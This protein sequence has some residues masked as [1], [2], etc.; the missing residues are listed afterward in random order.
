MRTILFAASTAMAFLSTGIADVSAKPPTALLTVGQCDQ[1]WE[2]SGDLRIV[3]KQTAAQK[4]ALAACIGQRSG[5]EVTWGAGLPAPDQIWLDITSNADDGYTD[6]RFNSDD[7]KWG[8][9][10]RS[11]T[12][13]L[14]VSSAGFCE[15]VA[16]NLRQVASALEGKAF[17]TTPASNPAFAAVD[18]TPDGDVVARCGPLLDRFEPVVSTGPDDLRLG[19]TVEEALRTGFLGVPLQKQQSRDEIHALIDQAQSGR[20]TEIA[21]TKPYLGYKSARLSSFFECGKLMSMDIALK[22]FVAGDWARLAK[23]VHSRYAGTQPGKTELA[24]MKAKKK[25]CVA[26]MSKDESVNLI[27]RR[28]GAKNEAWLR[29]GDPRLAEHAAKGCKA[30]LGQRPIGQ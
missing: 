6:V 15:A 20:L 19:M 23:T 10:Y 30:Q 8:W 26:A 25:D 4:E 21:V 11:K 2:C 9:R 3:D 27:W 13:K 18:I 12:K 1:S 24:D 28:S 22:P 5:T 14:P 29:F 17:D 16:T 7:G